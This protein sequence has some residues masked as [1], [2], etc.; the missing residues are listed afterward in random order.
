MIYRK[1][2]E[3]TE[4]MATWYDTKYTAMGGTWNT[5]PGEC[6]RHLDDLGVS[7]DKT[8]WLLDVGC[9]GGHFLVEAEKRVKCIGLEISPVAFD[10]A[11][12]RTQEAAI[13]KESIEHTDFGSDFFNYI[14]S[15]GSLEHII[16]IDKALDEIHRLLK[17]DGRWYFYVPNE[18]WEH[19]DQPNERT[20][21]E[22]E[23]EGLFA[24]HRLVT[25]FRKRWN[26]STAFAGGKEEVSS[27]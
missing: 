5:P 16:D 21:T 26:D 22:P 13:S 20:A 18:K 24:Q 27:G 23:W 12:E 25:D 2:L 8:K 19:F 4:E 3:T 11:F 17:G 7:F 14:V 6:N 10:F 15:I 1:S 9:G